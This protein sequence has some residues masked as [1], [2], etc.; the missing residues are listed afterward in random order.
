MFKLILIVYLSSSVGDSVHMI[1]AG[2][3]DSKPACIESGQEFKKQK[4]RYGPNPAYACI[5]AGA[6][7]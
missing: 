7:K 6:R 3:Y 2:V 5:P 4:P 1:D